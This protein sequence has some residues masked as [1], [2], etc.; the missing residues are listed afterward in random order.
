VTA[1]QPFFVVK[2]IIAIIG[3]QIASPLGSGLSESLR[4]MASDSGGA[5]TAA[6]HAPADAKHA[7]HPR[8]SLLIGDTV[9]LFHLDAFG[10]LRGDGFVHDFV[11]VDPLDYREPSPSSFED[12]L[13]QIEF[14]LNYFAQ[15]RLQDF[16]SR[17]NLHSE[18]EFTLLKGDKAAIAKQLQAEAALEVSQNKEDAKFYRGRPVEYGMAFQLRHVNTNKFLS[19]IFGANLTDVQG[20]ADVELTNGSMGSYF[21]VKSV[22]GMKG[23]SEVCC[24]REI[25]SIVPERL[26]TIAL[27]ARREGDQLLLDSNNRP[28]RS[29]QRVFCSKEAATWMI[30]RYRAVAD[31]LEQQNASKAN[32]AA[33]TE[34]VLGMPEEMARPTPLCS[35]QVVRL[36]HKE[37][38]VFLAADPGKEQTK[39][40]SV[41]R[42][43]LVS[44]PACG[45]GSAG[46]APNT[47]ENPGTSYSL[48]I[49]ENLDPTVAA[50]L[51]CGSKVCVVS[52]NV[53]VRT[54]SR[55]VC[56]RARDGAAR[57][58]VSAAEPG[59]RR[60]CS[61]PLVCQRPPRARSAAKPRRHAQR[62]AQ[63][64][65]RQHP[66]LHRPFRPR[67]GRRR[68]PRRRRPRVACGILRAGA[69]AALVAA[70]HSV[71]P[72][73]RV[74][75]RRHQGRRRGGHQIQQHPL[76]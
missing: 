23:D 6:L 9:S 54:L 15:E 47:R 51:Q 4:C 71:V 75:Q 5:G 58:A 26:P 65:A 61:Q 18:Q 28:L 24:E 38:D 67:G 60:L 20:S 56:V 43:L 46:W 8:S 31:V 48:W 32:S 29:P 62:L 19:A 30:S 66:Q 1:E 70:E 49:I 25:V 68:K 63:Q 13:F 57:V 34:L 53:C 35:G 69:A 50:P 3:S 33:D 16:V 52:V 22:R 39:D 2:P 42:S 41:K 76:P 7:Q 27:A 40:G 45:F 44:E 37:T 64:R 12:C 10:F 36:L 55:R 59:D 14:K 11:T 21:K 73:E 74:G 17:N 72:D